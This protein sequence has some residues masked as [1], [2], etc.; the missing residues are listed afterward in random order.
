[1]P[2]LYHALE[3]PIGHSVVAH[4]K[5]VQNLNTISATAKGSAVRKNFLHAS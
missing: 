5:V 4:K 2:Y 1:M 3:Q